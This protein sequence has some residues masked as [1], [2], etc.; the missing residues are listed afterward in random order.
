MKKILF[1]ILIIL[2]AIYLV[3]K[4]AAGNISGT[5]SYKELEKKHGQLIERAL[6]KGVAITH[7]D[8]IFIPFEVLESATEWIE[9]TPE[10]TGDGWALLGLTKEGKKLNEIEIP[11]YINGRAVTAIS[12]CSFLH[13]RKLISVTVPDSISKVSELAFIKCP[14]LKS[15]TSTGDFFDA[16]GGVNSPIFAECNVSEWNYSGDG[17]EFEFSFAPMEE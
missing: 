5:M 11:A 14:K 6:D 4:Y 9:V 10:S 7:D 1:R 3:S 2:L 8:M 16:V 12:F 15:I 13:C 17:L